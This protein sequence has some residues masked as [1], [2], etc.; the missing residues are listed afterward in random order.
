MLASVNTAVMT[1]ADLLAE[2]CQQGPAWL[3]EACPRPPPPRFSL[4]PIESEN[5]EPAQLSVFSP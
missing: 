4:G 2:F 5:N 3:L 1:E